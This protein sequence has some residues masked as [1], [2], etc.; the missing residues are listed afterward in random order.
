MASDRVK[1]T[2]SL[3]YGAVSKQKKL[4][5]SKKQEKGAGNREKPER[6]PGDPYQV[7]CCVSIKLP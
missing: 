3:G 2:V 4:A 7:P 5:C 6:D 1:P